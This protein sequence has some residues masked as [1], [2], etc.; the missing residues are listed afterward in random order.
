MPKSTIQISEFQVEFW[1]NV[2]IAAKKTNMGGPVRLYF[3][4]KSLDQAGSGKVKKTEIKKLC[5]DLG[6]NGKTFYKWL[7]HARRIELMRQVERK[8]GDK[9]LVLAGWVR[10][11]KII[12]CKDPGNR[13]ATIKASDFVGKGWAANVWAA[14]LSTFGKTISQAKLESLTGV[15]QRSQSRYNS[16]AGIDRTPNYHIMDIPHD[17]E[18]KEKLAAMQLGDHPGAWAGDHQGIFIRLPDTRDVSKI[19]ESAAIGRTRKIKHLLNNSFTS[20]LFS[21]AKTRVPSSIL[22]LF[23]ENAKAAKAEECDQSS[24]AA[25]V[26]LKKFDKNR[27]RYPKIKDIYHVRNRTKKRVF[28]SAMTTAVP[29]NVAV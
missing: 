6:V 9:W 27:S 4:A 10:G 8:N 24:K 15:P 2:L 17:E 29:Q 1:P 28:W 20:A 21:Y 7:S 19:A 3:L 16:E 23:H 25:R 13:K 22:R 12:G 11:F 14:A 18:F 26:T 5:I